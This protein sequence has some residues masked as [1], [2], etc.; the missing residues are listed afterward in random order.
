[1]RKLL[2]WV[3]H[4]PVISLIVAAIIGLV[5]GVPVV[6]GVDHYFSSNSFCATGCHVMESTVYA[7]LKQSTHGTSPAGVHP[8]CADCHL[9]D[10]LA[11]AMWQH[12]KGLTEL[13]AFTLGGIRTA[14]DF[15]KVRVEAADRTRLWMLANDS[16]GCRGCH[17]MEE[18][19]P[20]KKRGQRQHAD[21]LEEGTTCIAC[22][23]NLVH[24]EVEPSKQ[25]LQRAGVE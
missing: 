10:N 13:Y 23:Y 17:V 2:E 4:A 12:T 22:H 16:A 5:V 11:V 14:E 19:K 15:E 24:K 1:M 25:F 7:E 8:R 18:I 21:A 3:R 6:D 9:S 20:E